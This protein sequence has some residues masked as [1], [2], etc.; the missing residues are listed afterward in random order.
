MKQKVF[1]IFK[2]ISLAAILILGLISIVGTGGSSGGGSGHGTVNVNA[3]GVWD[4]TLTDQSNQT[5]DLL[6]VI[7]T[8]GQLRFIIDSGICAGSQYSGTVSMNGDTGSGNVT[9]Y[10]I[11]GCVFGNGQTTT[12]A[13][14]NFTISGANL[15][16][17]YTAPGD[18]G[19]YN[20]TYDSIAEVPITLNDLQGSWG[21]NFGGN[22]F[23]TINVSN[24]GSFSGVG[25]SGCNLSGQISIIDPDWSITNISVT[26]SNCTDA[27][28]NGTY[29]GLGLLE[30][31]AGGDLFYLIVSKSNLSYFDILGRLP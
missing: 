5:S 4:G 15:P 25:G 31:D 14:I 30:F 28:L 18:T 3:A 29:S 20:L 7:S 26:A 19:S 13:T 8:D 16:G 24:N 17:T 2:S 10:A 11:A 27:I 9:G 12:T 21:Y 6:G 23:L 1:I 22:N